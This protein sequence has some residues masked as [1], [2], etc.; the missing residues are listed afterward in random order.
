[1]TEGY[2]DQKVHV[3]YGDLTEEA[4]GKPLNYILKTAITTPNNRNIPVN[5]LLVFYSDPKR[6]QAQGTIE[7]DGEYG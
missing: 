2:G 6:R 7:W 3:T 4:I 1:M 5:H